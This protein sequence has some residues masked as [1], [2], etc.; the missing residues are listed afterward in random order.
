MAEQA[1]KIFA[2]GIYFKKETGAPSFVAGKV[3]IKKE[4]L[5][6]FLQEQDGDWVNL[7]AKEKQKKPGEFYLEV[8]TWKPKTTEEVTKE[9]VG[10]KEPVDLNSLD[11]DDLPF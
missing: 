11:A 8:D 5:I 2:K 6:A 7:V 9:Q 3:T 4:D 10:S 1:E